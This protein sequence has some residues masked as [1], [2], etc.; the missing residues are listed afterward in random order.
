MPATV[1][2][3][4]CLSNS[5][6]VMESTPESKVVYAAMR[7]ELIELARE[8]SDSE[9]QTAVPDCPAWTIGDVVAHVTGVNADV[10]NGDVARLGTDEWTENQVQSRAQMSVAEVCDE[11]EAIAPKTTDFMTEQPFMGVRLGADL[12]THIH[13]VLDALGR[14]D[15]ALTVAG[16]DGVGVRSALSRYGPFFCERVAN[17]SLPVVH[18]TVVPDVAGDQ[19]WRS[20]DE[21]ARATLSGAAF[22]LIRAFTGR[23]SVEQVLAMNWTGDP[24]PYLGV[25]N[26]Y[27]LLRSDR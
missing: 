18:V 27:G 26:P 22:D 10:V 24:E 8:L 6:D 4:R 11:W 21:P 19:N 20:G 15:E 1:A 5:L 12:V 7:A 3:T 9:L 17:A 16:R 23:R 14:S 2:R 13:D 25:I